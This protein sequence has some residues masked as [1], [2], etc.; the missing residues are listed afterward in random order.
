MFSD[1]LRGTKG[2]LQPFD[3]DVAVSEVNIVESEIAD[4]Q[5]L[6]FHVC[7]Q[8][9]SWPTPERL[10]PLLHEGRQGLRGAQGTA[11]KRLHTSGRSLVAA[12]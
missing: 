1:C 4:F 3:N 7:R 10:W 6:A 5:M 9:M 11:W 12:L 8:P 2:T